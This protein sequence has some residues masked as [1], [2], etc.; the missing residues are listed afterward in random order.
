MWCEIIE[1]QLLQLERLHQGLSE[2]YR[3]IVENKIPVVGEEV[4][5][6]NPYQKGVIEGYLNRGRALYNYLTGNLF[7][8]MLDLAG[9]PYRR[10]SEVLRL[11]GEEGVINLSHWLQL[12]WTFHLLEDH[13]PTFLEEGPPELYRA[14][15]GFHQL[16]EVVNRCYQFIN[17]RL[18]YLTAGGSSKN[19][20]L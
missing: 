17:S 14:I 5:Q 6:L 20:A 12:Q 3:L 2:Y 19:L 4:A 1:R 10:S 8:T 15:E 9:I 13:Y 18:Q 16:D 7:K 11:I